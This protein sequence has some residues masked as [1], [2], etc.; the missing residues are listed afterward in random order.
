MIKA[1][2]EKPTT[3]KKPR[4]Q[5]APLDFNVEISSIYA[6][7]KQLIEQEKKLKETKKDVLMRIK[8]LSSKEDMDE[9]EKGILK[10][11]AGMIEELFIDLPIKTKNKFINFFQSIW[12]F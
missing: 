8:L 9:K 11:V 3:P 10:D 12:K 6:D 2:Q 1:N 7:F 5:K 4:K